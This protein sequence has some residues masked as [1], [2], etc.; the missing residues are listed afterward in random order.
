MRYGLVS[1]FSTSKQQHAC[2]TVCHGFQDKMPIHA[3]LLQFHL[4]VRTRLCEM[5]KQ[6]QHAQ[7]YGHTHTHTHSLSLL[8]THTH[9]KRHTYPDLQNTDSADGYILTDNWNMTSSRLF[10]ASTEP[11]ED[12]FVKYLAYK[13]KTEKGCHDFVLSISFTIH[14]SKAH[15]HAHIHI[16]KILPSILC[17]EYWSIETII[18][19]RL[20]AISTTA[21]IWFLMHGVRLLACYKAKPTQWVI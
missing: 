21:S 13:E 11:A 8:L 9:T 6:N 18:Q 20:K 14:R 17:S 5:G 19:G 10:M 4:S 12:F 16:Y 15:T 2:L 3:N 7:T 1:D